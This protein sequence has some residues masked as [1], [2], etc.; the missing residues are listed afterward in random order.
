MRRLRWLLP[1]AILGI[2]GYVGVVYLQQ[3]ERLRGDSPKRPDLLK[4]GVEA[5]ALKYCVDQAQGASS[6]VRIC[7]ASMNRAGTVTELH[8]VELQLFHEDATEYDLVT[9]DFAKFDEAERK[10]FS[11]GNV[12]ITLAVP[13][14]GAPPGRLLKIHS[15]G[16]E[17]SSETGEAATVRPVRFDFDRGSG[18]AV[19]AHYN[20]VTR[21]LF[22]DNQVWLEWRSTT[23]DAQPMYIE[24]GNAAYLENQSKV[25]LQPWSKLTRGG[26]VMEGGTSE[27]LLKEG[28]IT[29]ADTSNGHGTQTGPGRNVEFAAKDLHILFDDHMTVNYILA[30]TNARLVSTAPTT[31]TTVTSDRLDLNFAAVD[32]ESVLTG[33]TATGK[34]IINAE[35]VARAGVPLPETRVL[36]SEIVR[37]IMRPGGEDIDRVE[38]GGPGTMDFLPNRPE[39]SKRTLKGDMIW[40]YY[41]PENRIEHFRSTNATTRTE[42]KPPR[43]TESK[44][45]LAYFD[46]QST[47]TRLE[48]NMDFRYE[49]GDRRANSK[50]ATF[51][52]AKNLLTLDGAAST[53]DPS[54]KVNA[55]HIT[56]DQETGD[57]V[58]EGSVFTTRQPSRKGGSSAMLSNEEIM[59][60][61]AKKMTSTEKNQKVHYEGDAKAWQGANRVSSDVLDID[62]IRHV[63]TAHG[64]VETQFY[65][66][67][68]KS[69]P[70]PVTTVRAPDLEYSTETRIAH[71]KGGVHLDRP[72]LTVDSKELRAFLKE[73]GS[74]SSLEKAFADGA[75]KMVSTTTVPGKPRRIRTGTSEHSE[76]YVDEQKVILNG[77][78]PRLVDTEKVDTTGRELT[79]WA[80][81]DRL[82]VDGQESKQ[83][84]TI[85]PKK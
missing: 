59:Q 51:E 42:T 45:I 10:L 8:G 83:V 56:L 77:G 12:E 3:L 7:A 39:Q 71:Y 80:N 11:E 82:L 6:K 4:S 38:T 60:A 36:R 31:R 13:A 22:M 1:V 23:P 62:Q 25:V 65:D 81:N 50:K 9:S 24:A 78:S 57:Y 46:T 76:Y 16:V 21:E 40:I 48:Q 69:G 53:S 85:I 49:E 79:W 15:S 72:G 68:T 19:G 66:K 28:S 26:L 74:D 27:I 35:P 75:V 73:T 2:L 64:K 18:S 5:S 41:G 84:R 37:M 52:Q 70:A 58:A 33:A 17:F 32:R 61:T 30:E 29:R 63:M 54:G 20:P 43:I 55:E 47:L 14:E 67:T 34:S 44:E